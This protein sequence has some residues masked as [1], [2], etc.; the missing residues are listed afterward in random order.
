MRFNLLNFSN[1][2]RR[3]LRNI[4]AF[5]GVLIVILSTQIL[6]VQ[7]RSSSPA[8]HVGPSVAEDSKNAPEVVKKPVFYPPMGQIPWWTIE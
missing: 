4:V 6:L 3:V 1:P 5:A 2:P 8:A 7:W